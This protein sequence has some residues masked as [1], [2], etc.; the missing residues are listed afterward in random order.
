MSQLEPRSGS[1]PSRRRR[2][3]RAYRLVL[4]TGAFGAIAVVGFVLAIVNVIGWSIPVL[5]V[6]FAV[7]CVLL[8]RRTVRA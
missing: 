2:E 8:F 5:A 4:A 6:V 3:E 7:I 1:R